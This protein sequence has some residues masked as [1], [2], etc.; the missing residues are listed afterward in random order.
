MTFSA[1]IM[2]VKCFACFGSSAP[3]RV[4]SEFLC[5]WTT[6]AVIILRPQMSV[7]KHAVCQ[8]ASRV[9]PWPWFFVFSNGL[10]VLLGVTLYA[11]AMLGV[12]S[13]FSSMRI[14]SSYVANVNSLYFFALVNCHHTPHMY[15][16]ELAR[17]RDYWH[18]KQLV[19]AATQACR[20]DTTVA[21]ILRWVEITLM[22]PWTCACKCRKF[23]PQSLPLVSGRVCR[24]QYIH[25]IP[26]QV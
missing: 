13:F 24:I 22:A 19:T 15:H 8:S 26:D 23:L 17:W 16:S 1:P 18:C 25:C 7:S 10:K 21:D 20:R 6:C 3:G 5:P 9:L 12:L 14:I 2:K 11:S 4:H